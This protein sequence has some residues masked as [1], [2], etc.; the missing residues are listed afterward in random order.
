MSNG[1]ALSVR[2]L[3]LLGTAALLTAICWRVFSAGVSVG[4]IGWA[5]ACTSP[6]WIPLPWL[7]HQ[8][9]KAYATLTLCVIP[10]LILGITEAIANPPWRAWAAFVLC[11]AFL[12]FVSL[13]AYLRVSRPAPTE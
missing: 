9:R 5:I 7:A 6:L 10:Y 8:S 11:V 2:N 13:I 4:K 12:L 3:V 1:L